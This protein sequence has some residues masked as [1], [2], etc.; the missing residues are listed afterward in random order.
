MSLIWPKRDTK[1]AR[2]WATLHRKKELS[3]RRMRWIWVT[4]GL[5]LLRRRA[6][7]ET[8]LADDNKER[9]DECSPIDIDVCLVHDDDEE[10]AETT[11][12]VNAFS[13]CEMTVVGYIRV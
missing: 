13:E 5:R 7:S 6:D 4:G 8:D 3:Y 2:F 12:A 1:C 10:M 9:N 11:F